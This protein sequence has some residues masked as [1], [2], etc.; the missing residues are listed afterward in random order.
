M[1]HTINNPVITITFDPTG[2]PVE[3][4]LTDDAASCTLPAER[5][6][7]SR[8]LFGD[9]GQRADVKGLFTGDLVVDLNQDY[10]NGR[11]TQLIWAAVLSDE[12]VE[13]RVRAKDAAISTSNPEWVCQCAVTSM[14]MVDGGAGEL[15]TA[16]LTM[17]IHGV[18]D[19]LTA[20]ES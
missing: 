20:P 6:V 7:V 14:P 12:L 17:P 9:E 1:G 13:V 4:D 8:P 19:L 3:Y 5:P 15:A 2:T 16:T 18:P 11:I 10:A